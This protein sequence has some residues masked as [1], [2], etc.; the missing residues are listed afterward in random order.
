MVRWSRSNLPNTCSA[1]V[2]L[3]DPTLFSAEQ[4]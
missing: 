4:V 1:V 3:V 2:V